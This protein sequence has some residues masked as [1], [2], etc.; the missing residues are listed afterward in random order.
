MKPLPPGYRLSFDDIDAAAAH[1]FL[2]TAY[3][4]EG[5][6][7]ATVQK[8][9]A[10]SLCIALQADGQGQGQV[11]FARVVTDRTTFAW[12]SDVFVD[13]SAR[14]QGLSKRLVGHIV[15][16]ADRMGLRR[17]L[18]ATG[19]AQGLYRKFG[20]AEID[21]DFSWMYKVWHDRP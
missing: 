3:W 6:P 13:R 21:D 9:I 15:D 11:G 19:D 2:T 10:H 16:E 5:I 12:L 20:F 18:L 17:V 7:L 4:C 8:A 14:G 1:A